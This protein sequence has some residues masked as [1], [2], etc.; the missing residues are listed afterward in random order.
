MTAPHEL[1]P[2][3]NDRSSTASPPSNEQTST[4]PASPS[5][6]RHR[7]HISLRAMMLLVLVFGSWLGWFVRSVRVQQ[8]AVAAIKKAGGTVVYDLEWRNGGSNP[9]RRSWVPEFLG[10]DQAWMPDWIIRGPGLDY[11]GNVVEASLIP[12]RANDP[13]AAN[14]ATLALVGQLRRLQGLRLNSTAI[15]DAG[16]AHLTSLT[17]LRDLQIGYTQIDDAGLA[18]IKGLTSLTSLYL[19]NTQVTDAGLAH[20][21]GLTN[22]RLLFIATTKVTDDGVLALEEALPA[23]F[24]YRE[25]EMALTANQSQGAQGPRFRPVTARPPCQ[26]AA[27]PARKRDGQSRRSGR[28]VG[29]D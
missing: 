15:T 28:A 4:T 19:M 10:G 29:D 6:R 21:R 9:Y 2:T 18:H 22:L 27:L 13:N 7:F 8:N 3:E 1:D 14:D 24:V 20:L 12:S 26:H 25:E 11:F 5:N 17:E 23:L 16:L